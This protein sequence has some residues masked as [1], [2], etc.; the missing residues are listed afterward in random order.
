[1]KEKSGWILL[2]V[3]VAL[4]LISL[5]V[6][7]AIQIRER[8]QAHADAAVT[9]LNGGFEQGFRSVDGVGELGVGNYW[10]PWW[11]EGPEHRPEY[12]EERVGV[13]SGRVY[14][15]TS[16]QKQFTTFSQQDGGIRQS[17]QAVPGQWYEFSAWVY[18]WSSS[19][20]D[21]NVSYVPGKCD[22][23]GVSTMVGINP[24]GGWD[25]LHRT[26]IWGQEQREVYDKWVKVT[27]IAQ[28]WG[29]EIT[30]FTRT[31]AK[32][33]VKH[34]DSYWDKAALKLAD[35]GGAVCPTPVPCPTAVP[36]VPCPA[37][38]TPV[39]CYDNTVLEDFR[40]IV[41]EEID[42]TRWGVVE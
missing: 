41:R 37:C 4:G 12:G 21:P 13:G 10:F 26:T 36:C 25:G 24:W 23:G 3:A 28:A 34:N 19:C 15:A 17:V 39:P 32:F 16:S 14:G 40:D 27:V 42:R 22:H 6:W 38:P 5:S 2:G 29:D 8:A 11:K 30:V 31:Q 9:L 1:M 20:D 33:S 7:G 35:M 18:V